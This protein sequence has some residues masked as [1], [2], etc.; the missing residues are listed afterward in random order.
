MSIYFKKEGDGKP[1]MIK[2]FQFLVNKIKNFYKIIKNTL[3]KQ[4]K[5]VLE[6]L[7]E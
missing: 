2:N 4:Q 6:Y 1:R 3:K 7:N 5:Q